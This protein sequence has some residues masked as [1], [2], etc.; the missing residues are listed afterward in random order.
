[1]ATLDW[2]VMKDRQTAGKAFL[3]HLIA[4][5]QDRDAAIANPAYARELFQEK[6]GM[7]LPPDIQIVPMSTNRQDRDKL[8]IIL[9]PDA[10]PNP[11]ILTYWIAAWVPYSDDTQGTN[12]AADAGN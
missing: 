7:K 11:D 4:N 9:V 8:N 1:M 2:N 6:G 12:K 3:V 5:P 10:D